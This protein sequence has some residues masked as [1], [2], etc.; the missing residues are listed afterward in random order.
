MYLETVAEKYVNAGGEIIRLLRNDNISENIILN[1]R[2]KTC[3]IPAHA[4][5][6]SLKFTFIGK[7]FYEYG[8][9]KVSV[10]PNNF[11]LINQGQEH[12]SWIE[13]ADWVDSSA[14]YFN[15]TFATG[16]YNDL[17]LSDERLID[18]PFE[19]L[20]AKGRICFFQNLFPNNPDFMRDV[21]LF[22]A[23]LEKTEGKDKLD[24]DEK[25]RYLLSKFIRIHHKDL[26]DKIKRVDAA[27]R[28]TRLEI[29]RRIHIA[30][31]F[32]ESFFTREITIRDISESCFLSENL[33]LRYF[34]NVF[35]LSPHQYIINKRLELAREFLET[36]DM[37]FNEITIVSGFSC[38]SSFGRLF[39]NRYGIT[40]NSLRKG[41]NSSS[42]PAGI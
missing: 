36:S 10:S 30:R 22:K 26:S 18:E 37:P 13:S 2:F 15:P 34:K 23:Y 42:Y 40:P 7:E 33:M 19:L 20:D 8:Q 29:V 28:S 41:A 14:I 27:K 31:D 38:A 35:G 3:H 16:V 17:T 1:T 9:K 24:I 5:N 12:E 11:L 25:L 39:K 21:S 6:L 4:D 32:I